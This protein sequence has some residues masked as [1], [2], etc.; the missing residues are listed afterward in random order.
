MNIKAY[1]YNLNKQFREHTAPADAR[2]KV[3]YA[4]AYMNGEEGLE[5]Y[6]DRAIAAKIAKTYNQDAQLAILFNKEIH[7]DEY[8]AYQA[9]RV[10]CKAAV[11]AEMATLKAELEEAL[12]GGV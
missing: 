4:R 8:E 11:D 6:R 10:E 7:P 1:I 9:F 2:V 12:A 3:S 5:R